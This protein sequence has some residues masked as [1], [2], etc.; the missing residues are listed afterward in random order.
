M[1]PLKTL[2]LVAILL[3]ALLQDTHAARAGNVG[4]EC[5]LQFYKGSIPQKVLVGW[6][7]TSDD[8]PNKAIVLVTRSGR[9]ICANPKDKTVKKAMKYLQKHKKS[10]ASALQES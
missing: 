6:Y 2:L 1:A 4:R 5:C 3:G 9:T 8:C 7:Q 10:P